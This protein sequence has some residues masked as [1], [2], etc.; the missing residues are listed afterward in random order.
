VLGCNRKFL[1]MVEYQM[2]ER[3]T[4]CSSAVDGPAGHI[5]QYFPRLERL[6]YILDLGLKFWKFW[7]SSRRPDIQRR[8]AW[9]AEGIF[10][11]AEG[12]RGPRSAAC[13]PCHLFSSTKRRYIS[14]LSLSC[15]QIRR[16]KY[17]EG[18]GQDCDGHLFVNSSA[19]NQ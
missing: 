2:S 9:P 5:R 15:S 11:P 7:K 14:C 12:Y 19:G 18:F 4:G 13:F 10:Q 1:M 17:S 8:G 6:S 3:E 16:Y